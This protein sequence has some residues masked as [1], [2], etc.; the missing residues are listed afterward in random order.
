MVAGAV[1]LGL[2]GSVMGMTGFEYPSVFANP[3]EFLLTF[4]IG[5]GV[6]FIAVGF[7]WTLMGL[8]QTGFYEKLTDSI[9][10]GEIR[11]IKSLSQELKKSWKK[12]EGVSR[13]EPD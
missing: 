13:E 5:M 12:N 11:D 6:A 3:L 2:T 7:L 4:G 8:M 10:Q 1:V 9:A